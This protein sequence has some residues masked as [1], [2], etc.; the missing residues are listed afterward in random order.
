MNI[1]VNELPSHPCVCPFAKE[2]DEIR[3]GEVTNVT[4]ECSITKETCDLNYD[5]CSGLTLLDFK[6]K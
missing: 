5:K 1:L 6:E 4:F 3:Y 2:Y